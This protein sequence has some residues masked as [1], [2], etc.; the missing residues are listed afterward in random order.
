MNLS[1]A[2]SKLSRGQR[3]AL[4]VVVTVLAAAIGMAAAQRLQDKRDPAPPRAR[5]APAVEVVEVAPAPFVLTRTYRGSVAAD[6]RAVVSARITARVL[7]IHHREG[8]MVAAGEPLLRLDDEELRREADRLEAVGQRLAGELEVATRQLARDRELYSERM[9]PERSLDESVQRAQGLEAQRRENR[10]ALALVNTRLS[11]S[12]ERA[13]FD[14]IV[15]HNHVQAGEL[16]ALGQPLIELVSAA[17]LKAVIAVPQ[18]DASLIAP[19]QPVELEVSALRERWP[20]TVDRIYPA[21]D[22]S[23]RN[24]TVAAFFPPTAPVRPGMA[25][26]AEVELERLRDALS[27]PAHAVHRDASDTWVWLFDAGVARRQAVRAGATREGVT[28]IEEGLSAGVR[29]IV[30]ADR[31]LEDGALVSLPADRKAGWAED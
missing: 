2:D 30:T 26:T 25:V 28:L 1:D 14:G 23:T 8:A 6:N 7:A 13:P 24:A 9:I 16:A 11:Y 18:A 12:I 15:Q 17:G 19:G 29:V 31:R 10:A 21:L 20:G 5:P 4:F 3:T 22:E 27:V